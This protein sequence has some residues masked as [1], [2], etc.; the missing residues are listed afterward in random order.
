MEELTYPESFS[1]EEL[2]WA[3]AVGQYIM[4]F[5]TNPKEAGGFNFYVIGINMGDTKNLKHLG[6]LSQITINTGVL[7]EGLRKNTVI[8]SAV[9]KKMTPEKRRFIFESLNKAADYMDEYSPPAMQHRQAIG[10]IISMLPITGTIK[11]D[12]KGKV[13]F[14]YGK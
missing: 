8:S 4:D 3:A 1:P 5:M 13:D 12:M 14:D 9:Y 7:D 2:L 10:K 6:L 11:L